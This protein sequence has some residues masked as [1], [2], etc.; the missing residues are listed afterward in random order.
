MPETVG[1]VV[2]FPL[3]DQLVPLVPDQVVIVP[4]D[5]VPAAVAN[6]IRVHSVDRRAEPYMWAVLVFRREVF[7]KRGPIKSK[8]EQQSTGYQSNAR[9]RLHRRYGI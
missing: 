4:A 3:E 1:F 8:R 6:A 7:M 2:Q 5:A 9:K